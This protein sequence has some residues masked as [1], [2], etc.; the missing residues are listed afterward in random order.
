MKDL[1]V[2]GTGLGLTPSI[3]GRLASWLLFSPRTAPCFW[4]K[5]CERI[6][7][8]RA[9]QP[10]PARQHLGHAHEPARHEA[11]CGRTQAPAP[12]DATAPGTER[13]P[14]GQ[15]PLS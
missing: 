1:P 4:G 15:G 3:L 2:F 5:D 12:A 6:G 11:E 8:F 10:A 14:W 9:A 7:A 13:V